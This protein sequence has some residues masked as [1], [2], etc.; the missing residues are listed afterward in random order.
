ALNILPATVGAT[1][2]DG[3]VTLHADRGPEIHASGVASV[4]EGARAICGI[5]PEN[6]KIDAQRHSPDSIPAKVRTVIF[7]GSWTRVEV[8]LGDGIAMTAELAG[9]PAG[10]QE[11]KEVFVRYDPADVLVYPE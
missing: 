11:G 6:L 10:I 7:G 2:L 4:K 9:R 8:T 1:Q 5:R 3:R